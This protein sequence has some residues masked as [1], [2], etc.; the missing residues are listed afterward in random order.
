MEE[1]TRSIDAHSVR[2]VQYEKLVVDYTSSEE[3][4]ARKNETA[5]NSP[6]NGESAQTAGKQTRTQT[7][8]VGKPSRTRKHIIFEHCN[9]DAIHAKRV[10]IMDKDA[11][12][13]ENFKILLY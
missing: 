11:T 3:D 2:E 4:S 12:F 9:L 13:V 5:T 7:Q 8:M 10:T 1:G 6:P